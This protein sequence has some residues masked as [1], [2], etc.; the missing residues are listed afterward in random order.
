MDAV[1]DQRGNAGER[2]QFIPVRKF[3]VLHALIEQRLLGGERE[4]EQFPQ[5][6]RLLGA[7]LHYEYFDQLERLERAIHQ[8][9]DGQP[10]AGLPRNR[11][12]LL[13]RAGT[14]RRQGRV[15]VRRFA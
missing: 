10:N 1:S 15:P 14:R 2:D 3:D 7:I 13:V 11:D 6:C 8:L 4:L 12:C 9:L 5:L